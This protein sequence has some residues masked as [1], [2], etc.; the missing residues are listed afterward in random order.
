MPANMALKPAK[1]AQHLELAGEAGALDLSGLGP[2]PEPEDHQAYQRLISNDLT[3]EQVE[4]LATPS[5]VLPQEREV[6][7]IHWHPEFIPLDLVRRRLQATFPHLERELVIP[8]QHNVLMTMGEYAG[9]EV[10]CY[11]KGFKRKVQ[12]LMHFRAERLAGADVFRAMLAHTFQYRSSQLHEFIASVVEPAWEHRLQEAAAETG[13]G[14]DLVAFTRLYTGRLKR[15]LEANYEQ[16]P[17]SAIKNK[18]LT[19]YFDSLRG[20]HPDR[21]VTRAQVLLK[22]VKAV[23]KREFSLTYFYR[24]SEV[25]EEAR[26][27]GCGIVIPHPEQFWPILLADYDVDGYEV[28]NPQSREYTEFLINVLNRQNRAAPPDRRRLMVFMGDDTHL[29]EKAKPPELQKPG[30]AAREVGLQPAWQDLAIRKSLIVADM[31]RPK[32][33]E[34]YRARLG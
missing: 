31:D 19:E 5:T 29:G 11:S 1:D 22:A 34:E 6:L 14:E 9:V 20:R 2:E 28:W 30:K 16:T 12:L 33:I 10:D 15:L 21:V 26:S 7:A 17:A 4:R 23:V 27:V 18:L 8:T 24:A 25:I 32:V 3:P 13:A